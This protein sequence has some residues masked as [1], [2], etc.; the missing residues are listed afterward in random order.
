[1]KLRNSTTIAVKTW[2]TARDDHFEST[3]RSGQG[4]NLRKAVSEALLDFILR[5]RFTAPGGNS[6][7]L[8][9]P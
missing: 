9:L 7:Q 6:K 2:R 3:R 5:Y 1:M 4:A 8:G